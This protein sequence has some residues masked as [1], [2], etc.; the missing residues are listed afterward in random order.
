M[1]NFFYVLVFYLFAA[2]LLLNS[3]AVLA[4]VGANI[5]YQET[6]SGDGTYRYDYVFYNTSTA[7][8][9][10]YA[11]YLYFDQEA[12]IT[13]LPLP[14]GW[15]G[16][17]WEGTN[18]TDWLETFSMDSAYDISAGSSLNGFSFL[19]DYLA[20]SIPFTAYFEDNQGKIYEFTDYTNIR[21][22]LLGDINGDGIVDISDVILVLKIA[23]QL[24]PV[25]SCS[26]INND[27]VVDI[28]DVILTL[29]MA[30]GLDELQ[31]CT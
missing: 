11:V 1:K 14:D 3:S 28:A 21:A 6:D 26:D 31:P 5:I 2:N 19:I 18:M 20:G 24:D 13:G 9:S 8:E 7:G 15:D 4:S 10:L 30:L 29:R 23:L 12:T 25:Q 27:G 17:I 22:S 16:I